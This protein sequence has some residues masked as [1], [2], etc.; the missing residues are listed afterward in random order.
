[1]VMSCK[2]FLFTFET[3]ETFLHNVGFSVS[4]LSEVYTVND[5][6]AV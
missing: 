4:V 1:M 3:S 2:L 5:G 6:F